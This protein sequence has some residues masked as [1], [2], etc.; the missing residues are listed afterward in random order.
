MWQSITTAMQFSFE[1]CIDLEE[2]SEYSC[3]AIAVEVVAK[4]KA[5]F[6]CQEQDGGMSSEPLI[7]RMF[8]QLAC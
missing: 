2:Y 4:T 6:G 3:M 8:D 7:Q 5:L 1:Y